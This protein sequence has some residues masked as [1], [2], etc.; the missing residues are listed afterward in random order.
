VV[1]LLAGNLATAVALLQLLNSGDATALR[2]LH[3]AVSVAGDAALVR[4]RRRPAAGV[5][6]VSSIL[7]WRH[8]RGP[9]APT[10]VNRA[11][12]AVQPYGG[13][14]MHYLAIDC[15]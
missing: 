13:L 8:W 11:G 2:R 9:S 12:A 6:A 1:V 15:R 5:T 10:T 3:P 4:H 7:K 14:V